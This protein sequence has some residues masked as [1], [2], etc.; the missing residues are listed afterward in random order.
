MGVVWAQPAAA[1]DATPEQLQFAAQEDD[2]GYRAYVAKRYDEAATHFEK[3]F[4]AAPNPAELR[5]AIRAH[6]ESGAHARAATLAALALRKFDTDAALGKLADET[7]AE[8]KPTVHEVHLTS[9]EDCSVDVD[10]RVVT[11]EKARDF[12]FFLDPGAH[13]LVVGWSDQ[14]ALKLPIQAKAGGSLTLALQ[15]PPRPR[16]PVGRPAAPAPA[17][18]EPHTKPLGPVLFLVGA[19]VTVTGLG[20]TIWSG[21]DAT[22]NPGTATV[23]AD[24]V[25]QGTTCPQYQEGLDAQRRTNILITATAGVGALTL[26]T[27]IF[28]TQWK[29]AEQPPASTAGLHV[30][31]VLGLDRVGIRGA[32]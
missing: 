1:A 7:I 18:V 17:H 14:R 2:L 8:A 22:K 27:G 28:F 13:Q 29:V 16:P 5:K 23:K 21:V 12:R 10:D 20:L 19:G 15:P 4:F 32:F 25:G 6:R 9:T 3:A 26:V 11:V 30:E 31:P 24:C